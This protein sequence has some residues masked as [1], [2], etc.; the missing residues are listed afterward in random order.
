MHEQWEELL[1]RMSKGDRPR[2]GPGGS[3]AMLGKMLTRVALAG[4]PVPRS[5]IGKGSMLP[6]RTVPLAS[7]TVGKAVDALIGEDLLA[8]E[9]ITKSGQPGPPIKPLRFSDKWAIIG[10]HIDQQHDGPDGLAGIICGLD[11]KPLTELLETTVPRQG[12]QHDKRGLAGE[13]RKLTESLLEQLDGKRRFLGVGIEIGGHVDR[14]VIED[15]VHAGWSQKVDLYQIL[16]DEL[17]EIPVLRGVPGVAENDVNALAIH[18]YYE[19][20]FEKPDVALVTVF[21][22]GVGGGL[23][24]NGRMYRGVHGMAP[25]PGHL[26]VEYP[27]DTLTWEPP[28]TPRTAGG[29][30]FGDECLCSTKDRKRYGHVETLAT[31]VRIEGQ[32][33]ALTGEKISLEKAAVAPSARA[34]LDAATARTA[35]VM[36]DPEAAREARIE[37]AQA[38]LAVPRGKALVFT[39]EAVVLRRAGR[40]LGRGLV[41]MINLLNPGQIILRLPEALATPMPQSSGAEYLAAVESE[42]DGAYSTGPDDA[43]NGHHRLAVQGYADN[44]VAYDGAVAAATTVLNAFVE[45]ARGRDGC[46]VSG[47]GTQRPGPAR[48]AP[49]A[50]ASG[51]PA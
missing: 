50:G 43:R 9:G 37:A 17:G 6:H 5:A 14:G 11:R 47:E 2:Y 22:Q 29:R 32:L 30:T 20:S 27:E 48:R 42:V 10:I 8:E 12:D 35:A 24:L 44:R 39:D 38:D 18:G 4:E 45:H 25:E 46:D 28:P 1:Q 7:G 23:T 34:A 31:P 49:R 19:H 13:I 51:R 15:S 3:P 36:Q 21:R 26:P 40:A 16:A 33:A 41:E